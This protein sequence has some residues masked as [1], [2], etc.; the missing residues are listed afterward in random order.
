MHITNG[1]LVSS[2]YMSRS[3]DI[4]L[5]ENESLQLLENERTIHL[6]DFYS[7]SSSAINKD[8]SKQDEGEEEAVIISLESL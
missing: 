3:I 2:E 1:K 6:N 7:R 5:E 4:S 8:N